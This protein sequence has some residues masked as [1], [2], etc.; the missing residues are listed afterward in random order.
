[1]GEIELSEMLLNSM[2]NIW[3]KQAYVQ[4]FGCKSINFNK[5]FNMFE[6]MF[7]AVY[8]YEGVVEPSY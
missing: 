5:A 1:M 7:I 3:S 2:P 6:C 4:V 8:I